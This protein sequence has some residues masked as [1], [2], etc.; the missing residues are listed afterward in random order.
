MTI[1]YVN[2][3]YLEKTFHKP[4]KTENGFESQCHFLNPLKHGT[5]TKELNKRFNLRYFISTQFLD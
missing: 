4:I 2:Q 1:S 3:S 5:P